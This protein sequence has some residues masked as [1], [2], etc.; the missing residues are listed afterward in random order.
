VL[1]CV[2]EPE[3]LFWYGGELGTKVQVPSG[4]SPS[5]CPPEDNR[6][7]NMESDPSVNSPRV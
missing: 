1:V 3:T 7:K 4:E 2:F 6:S 5:V